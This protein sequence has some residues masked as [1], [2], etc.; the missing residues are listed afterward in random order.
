MC[1]VWVRVVDG[2]KMN[3]SHTL[4]ARSVLNSVFLHHCVEAGLDMAIVNYSK[5]YPLYKIPAE[6]VELARKL[7]YQDRSQGDPLQNY[8]AFFAGREKTVEE[9]VHVESL[10]FE[11]VADTYF[12]AIGGS[13]TGNLLEGARVEAVIVVRDGTG[14]E[15]MGDALGA[16]DDVSD[17]VVVVAAHQVGR[18]VLEVRFRGASI[19]DALDISIMAEEARITDTLGTTTRLVL[20]GEKRNVTLEPSTE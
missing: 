16:E 10:T 8:V 11:A 15:R 17:E 7:I 18:E 5:I 14:E 3:I 9:V 6:E 19:K 2:V 13:A 4:E 1:Q 12:A 20:T